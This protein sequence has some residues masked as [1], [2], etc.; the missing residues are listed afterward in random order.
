MKLSLA[1]AILAATAATTSARLFAKNE[2]RQLQFCATIYDPVC[3]ADG[4]TYSNS[5]EAEVAGVAVISEGECPTPV[6]PTLPVP[7]PLD[8]AL[9]CGADG[10]TY[11]NTCLAEAAGTTVA[12]KGECPE[13]PTMPTATAA[14]VS[15]CPMNY[16]PVC[17][18]DGMTYDNTCLA[19]AAGTTI[20][21]KGVCPEV[22]TMPTATACP[23]NIDTVCG[24]DGNSYDNEC[25]AQAAGTTVVSKGECTSEALPVPC[26][27]NIAPVCG[28]DGNSY[29]NECLAK[30]A[31]TTVASEE[32][33]PKPCTEEYRPVCGEDGATYDNVCYAEAA[34]I[35]VV[36]EGVCAKPCTLEYVPVCGSNGMTYA[37]ECMAEAA[38]VEGVVEG[39]C[40]GEAVTCAMNY[41]PV[42]GSDGVTYGNS[43]QAAQ[44]AITSKG[45][46]PPVVCTM[47]YDPQ[48]GKDGMQYSNKCEAEAAGAEIAYEGECMACTMEFDP[49]C[50][51]VVLTRKL[52]ETLVRLEQLIC[53]AVA[54]FIA[55]KGECTESVPD[56]EVVTYDMNSE[57][58]TSPSPTVKPTAPEATSS[59]D[60][61]EPAN[62]ANTIDVPVDADP[63]VGSLSDPD[64]PSSASTAVI[65]TAT[66][67]AH[68][69]SRR[70]S[71][72]SSKA[73]YRL[74]VDNSIAM[75]KKKQ[76]RKTNK[77]KGGGS[78]GSNGAKRGG[79]TH[80][81]SSLIKGEIPDFGN[82]HPVTK[83]N[84]SSIYSCYK[85]ATRR[86][87]KF[88]RDNV[89]TS[90]IEDDTSCNFLLTAA[91][92]MSA[93]SQILDPN[94]M[95]DLKL[96]IRMR[97]RVAKSMF[98]GGDGGHKYFLQV[99]VYSSDD[100]NDAILF[101]LSLDELAEIIAGQYRV[102]VRNI[103][104][105]RSRGY[106]DATMISNLMD[107]TIMANFSI[108]AVQKM[109]IELQ[110]Q[111]E[112]LTTPCR[113]LACLA[114]PE[115]TAEVSSIVR[116]R[117]TKQCDRHE[118]IAFL[119]D[120]MECTFLN[121]SDEWNRMDSIVAEF[122]R[123]YGVDTTG[124]AQIEQIFVGI[125][126]MTILEVPIKPEITTSLNRMRA[127]LERETGKPHK[128]HSWLPH[129]E[130]IGGD[131]AIH[132]TVRLLQMFAG[133]ID[134][135]PLENKL[136]PAHKGMFGRLIDRPSKF[137][138]M[139]ELLMSHQLVLTG[140]F[141]VASE[142]QHVSTVSKMVFDNYFNQMQK[143]LK[144][145]NNDKSSNM[146]KSSAMH[147]IMM[148]SFL[149]NFGLPAFEESAIAR[150]LAQ[151]GPVSSGG[152]FAEG[153]QHCRGRTMKPIEPSEISTAF[154]RIC[155]RDFSD[156]VDK[157]HTPEQ[158]K[159]SSHTEQYV[160]AVH[161]N[162]TLDHL[163]EEIQLHS[164]NFIS[165]ACIL[166]QFV[167]SITRVLQ[168][169][170][171]LETFKRTTNLDIRQGFAIIFAQHLLG[172]LDF[173][174]DPLNYEFRNAPM[175]T[176][177]APT[178]FHGVCGFLDMYFSNVPPTNVFWFQGMEAGGDSKVEL[179]GSG[180]TR[181]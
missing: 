27:A 143:S 33:C 141:E 168:W 45:E 96:C 38:G 118:I 121:P 134:N 158:R 39:V 23:M 165:T 94:V 64:A 152:V 52:T 44:A 140:I 32:A 41:D 133:V 139:D 28:A 50:G 42:C 46:C 137:S 147:N 116:E 120:S 12:S 106:S 115:L 169:D 112:H 102:M 16:E 122:S 85:S 58:T 125:R 3:G 170:S 177:Q 19:E 100:R 53:L 77:K 103:R 4:R 25:L 117:G 11:D 31:G 15:A 57:S 172:A 109:E 146:K 69:V 80:N 10:V 126:H 62:P 163:E 61:A 131:R 171:L 59:G 144:A 6:Q 153:L 107:A 97:N 86:F 30:A 162:D 2:A 113:L 55:Y 154:R 89:P 149:E 110:T 179:I 92:W 21:S 14:T 66:V 104:N 20:A 29:D 111:H 79:V 129:M 99:L 51:S 174:Q 7:C 34:G 36:S 18:A 70:T 101:L 91:D 5:C 161:T 114:M 68:S 35:T 22:P 71:N 136:G 17:G 132:R 56:A 124:S 98:G 48:C 24:A 128:S 47:E 159:R 43:C 78:G 145:L 60:S 90:L 181:R 63:V 76:A 160:V 8:I 173:A 73:S 155:D 166:E 108:Q 67:L 37:N 150:L 65:G 74:V 49:Q 72:Q 175:L 127:T 75:V 130:F 135:C 151:G 1:H 119:G 93:N 105:N 26:P 82:I 9:V 13:V 123:K 180:A 81:P 142:R 167:C 178:L 83:S 54:D 164:V 157:Y 176:R 87:L 138:D 148:V 88:M 95:K 84:Y 156:V 40:P